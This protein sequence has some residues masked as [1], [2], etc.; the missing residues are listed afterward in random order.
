[1]KLFLAF[2]SAAAASKIQAG[3]GERFVEKLS[4]PLEHD[5]FG[6]PK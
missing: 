3:N 5:S 1:M 2:F 4:F 6:I